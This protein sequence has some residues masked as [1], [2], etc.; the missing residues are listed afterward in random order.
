M[1]GSQVTRIVF[2][3]LV[4]SIFSFLSFFLY[5]Y[6]LMPATYI[7][8]QADQVNDTVQKIK[9]SFF[10]NDLKLPAFVF[11]DIDQA[12]IAELGYPALIPRTVLA[13][14]AQ[15][16]LNADPKALYLDV[17]LGW[18]ST[19]H[20][21]QPL[22]ELL[23]EYADSKSTIML[24]HNA[25]RGRED[26]QAVFL[27]TEFDAAVEAADNIHWV[28]AEN[29]PD[30][31][32]VIRKSLLYRA[33]CQDGRLLVR[34][35][36][37]L[38]MHLIDEIADKDKALWASLP[39]ADHVC[40]ITFE[41]PVLQICGQGNPKSTDQVTPECSESWLTRFSLGYPVKYSIGWD[42]DKSRT[43]Q[44]TLLNGRSVPLLSV[45]PARLILDV[46]DPIS[47]DL[48]EDRIVI[49]GSSA[50]DVSDLHTTSIGTA[51]PG[52]VVVANQITSLAAEGLHPRSTYLFSMMTFFLIFF[53]VIIVRH[54]PVSNLSIIQGVR[55]EIMYIILLIIWPL[56]VLTVFSV[57]LAFGASVIGYFVLALSKLLDLIDKLFDRKESIVE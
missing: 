20:D 40:P 32:G 49:V 51:V 43:V 15:A 2:Q 1:R 41:D 14:I 28:V 5:F 8:Q 17:D 37:A 36:A 19:Q 7:G 47:P 30:S 16:A 29:N 48:F 50:L 26:N 13:R 45:V 21:T 22:L 56:F 9:I 46:K 38:Q 52:S 10:D 6:I 25:R 31:D 35:S 54:L 53:G 18:K 33:A 27:K 4:A 3:F 34:P 42:D 44:R 39:N 12:T 23:S 57:S 11:V 55:R 24:L